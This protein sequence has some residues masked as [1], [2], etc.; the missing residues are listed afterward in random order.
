MSGEEDSQNL[1]ERDLDMNIDEDPSSSD[2]DPVEDTEDGIVGENRLDDLVCSEATSYAR[3]RRVRPRKSKTAAVRRVM[4]ET[5]FAELNQHYL[6]YLGSKLRIPDGYTLELSP[7]GITINAPVDPGYVIVCVEHLH[8]GVRIP[9]QTDLV[10]L[11]RWYQMPLSQFHPNGIRHFFTVRAL[12]LKNKIPFSVK[13][14]A[15]MY[16]LVYNGEYD[17][18]Y[19]KILKSEPR[20]IVENV[21]TS[22]K[23]FRVDWFRLRHPSAFTE[24]PRCWSCVSPEHTFIRR[25][26]IRETAHARL[27]VLLGQIGLVNTEELIPRL[28]IVKFNPTRQ[29][30]D[31]AAFTAGRRPRPTK[32]QASRTVDASQPKMADVLKAGGPG[33][34][35]EAVPPLAEKKRKRGKTVGKRPSDQGVDPLSVEID[36][37]EDASGDERPNE[38]VVLALNAG[39]AAAGP[40]VE[41]VSIPVF[42][43]DLPVTDKGLSRKGKGKAVDTAEVPTETTAD[44]VLTSS[45]VARY[46]KRKT[47]ADTVENYPTALSL[48]R[49]C[50]LPKDVDGMKIVHPR[51]FIDGGCSLAFQLINHLLGA[52]SVQDDLVNQASADREKAESA[53]AA[54][55]SEQIARANVQSVLDNHIN[56]Y[57]AQIADLKKEVANLTEARVELKRKHELE[58]IKQR[59][60][61]DAVLA[62]QKRLSSEELE[63]AMKAVRTEVTAE[64]GQLTDLLE[65]DLKDR[66]GPLLLPD[67]DPEC[68]YLDVAAMYE[69]F[70]RKKA[71]VSDA[72][73]EMIAELSKEFDRIDQENAQVASDQRTGQTTV[74]P[75][76]LGQL[77]VS[78]YEEAGLSEG[79]GS[80]SGNGAQLPDDISRAVID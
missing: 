11:L 50:S 27:Q 54:L 45:A 56:E 55:E 30:M 77:D 72:A 68:L 4:M 10:E 9:F 58:L 35:L 36:A 53:A 38:P 71:E 80:M 73:T 70:L 59:E 75:S 6:D 1:S 12:C 20:R 47:S 76:V 3:P 52:R 57:N 32:G 51:D 42:N 39:M 16:G 18:A 24:L 64:F 5:T 41:S 31:M 66:V 65:D 29:A 15:S 33:V 63:K 34:T 48:A 62:E 26:K 28:R 60:Q 13:F 61:H 49:L 17:F 79:G 19:F 67:A 69:V 2:S 43:A 23:R 22:L 14:F 44:P 46:L 37:F 78:H 25:D 40:G 8:S 7:P 74:A 21:T